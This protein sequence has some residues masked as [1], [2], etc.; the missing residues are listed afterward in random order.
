MAPRSRGALWGDEPSDCCDVNDYCNCNGKTHTLQILLKEETTVSVSIP[1]FWRWISKREEIQVMSTLGVPPGGKE[2]GLS[3]GPA[4]E[5]QE[6]GT[7]QNIVA[8]EKKSVRRSGR[9]TRISE[10]RT[11]SQIRQGGSN[12][13]VISSEKTHNV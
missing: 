2:K 13:G 1:D 3:A 11:K 8:V 4:G 10:K 5:S 7:K 6:T 9:S 12:T